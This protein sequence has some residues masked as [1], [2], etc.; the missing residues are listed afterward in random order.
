MKKGVWI[1]FQ[2]VFVILVLSFFI[3]LEL[4]FLKDAPFFVL[5][6]MLGLIVFFLFAQ[7]INMATF[8]GLNRK[9][10]RLEILKEVIQ[11]PA[12]KNFTG[13]TFLNKIKETL[14][15]EGYPYFGLL[16]NKNGRLK[17]AFTN[18]ELVLKDYET[19]LPEESLC[20]AAVAE[21][22]P[23]IVREPY[24]HPQSG[25]FEKKI[26]FTYFAAFPLATG[27]S[28]SGV[29]WVAGEFVRLTDP[30]FIAYFSAFAA[31][32]GEILQS[33][34]L[35]KQL[36]ETH[37]G[38]VRALS[39]L[40]SYHDDRGKSH[41]ERVAVFSL[42]LAK[43]CGLSIEEM[44]TLRSAAL[45]H[46]LFV[47]P[48]LETVCLFQSSLAG[49]ERAVMDVLE[50]QRKI[51]TP[52]SRRY[53]IAAVLDCFFERYDGSGLPKG[54]T[55]QEIPMAAKILSVA[56]AFDR[57][58]S[59]NEPVDQVALGNIVQEIKEASGRL[60]DPR[61]VRAL[62]DSVES[63]PLTRFSSGQPKHEPEGNDS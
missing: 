62:V 8:S 54:M 4:S 44:E 1:A 48:E 45:L 46:H 29:I 23:V 52:I 11:L 61:V 56:N 41:A 13:K 14:L 28:V 42:I 47:E 6:A 53:P 27:Q 35:A 37:A 17:S 12:D 3:Y 60:F 38:A 51:L 5:G 10:D 15:S 9:I 30:D 57:I 21:R 25:G 22:K 2:S 7:W 40:A 34:E 26:P 33:G 24:L 18:D 49:Y 55:G 16:L 59:E 43:G 19:E 63:L 31:L 58:L 32:I 36:H 50:S 39:E 20:C